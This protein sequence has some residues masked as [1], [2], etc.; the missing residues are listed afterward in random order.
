MAKTKPKRP[1]N[2]REG[3]RPEETLEVGDKGDWMT[4]RLG[5]QMMGH[6]GIM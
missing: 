2:E 4:G 5:M 1:D 6:F 3:K